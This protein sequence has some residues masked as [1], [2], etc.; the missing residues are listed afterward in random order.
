MQKEPNNIEYLCDQLIAGVVEPLILR[1]VAPGRYDIIDGA[2]RLRAIEE[3]G[4]K[5]E[6]SA[7]LNTLAG[8][9]I[10]INIEINLIEWDSCFPNRF[11][12]KKVLKRVK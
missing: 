9:L 6:V 11:S 10:M 3:A 1:E 4:L 8:D 2:C 12:L 7:R 5:E